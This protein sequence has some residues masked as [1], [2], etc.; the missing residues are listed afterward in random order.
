MPRVVMFVTND[1]RWDVRVQR[2]AATLAAAGYVVTV[3]GRPS[4]PFATIAE[5]ERW[6][7]VDIIRVPIPG[8]FRRRMLGAGGGRS[9]TG[10]AGPSSASGDGGGATGGSM[11]PARLLVR[12][13]RDAARLP[14]IGGLVRGLDLLARWRFG[15]VAWGSAAAAAA[16][17]ADVWHAHDLTGIPA[18][19]EAK[20]RH[21]GRLVY[22]SHEL[23]TEAGDTA[24]RPGWAR[25]V[26]R[27]YE[28]RAIR[29]ADAVVTVNDG[30]AAELRRIAPPRRLVV[31][32]NTPPAPLG[33]EREDR[34]R[35]PPGPPP[36]GAL[37]ACRARRS[38]S[39][40]EGSCRIEASRNSSRRWATTGPGA[41][42]PRAHGLRTDGLDDR[43]AARRRPGAGGGSTSCR[44]FRPTNSAPWV[45]SADVG[46]MPNQPRTANERISTP[47]KLYECL[48]A[49]TPVVSSDFPERR[50]IIA[51]DPGGPLGAL[52][53]P[54]DPASIGA[55]LRSIL[56]LDADAAAALR[57][58]CLDAARER[59]NW[60]S[61]AEGLLALYGQLAPD[62]RRAE[63]RRRASAPDDRTWPGGPG[64]APKV[65][66][67]RDVRP[68]VE[69]RLR[70][71][72][73]PDGAR[74]RRARARR[75]GDRASR[76]GPAGSRDPRARRRASPRRC[77]QRTTAGH[78][79]RPG[80]R[81]ALSPTSPGWRATARRT[82]SQARAAR[83]V[84]RPAAIYHAMGFL[85]LPVAIDLA[86][87]AERTVRLRRP[88]P[89]R[90]GQQHR[91]AA[92]AVARALRPSRAVVGAP[93]RGGP[94]GE[95]V[96]RG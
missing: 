13:V 54:T 19:R 67:A 57:A 73:P 12:I 50:R 72:D 53:D 45:A 64:A 38:S 65:P 43:R 69:R 42:P 55:A 23:F 85:A 92:A 81:R 15:T 47:N 35:R 75:A 89:L 88:R 68:A 63:P 74:P 86:R 37:P 3:I 32:R 71:P 58:R 90:G 95:R 16:P 2:E 4:D 25:A 93:G 36:P 78:R 70:C 10:A 6:H 76:G 34:A 82:R 1:V 46:A 44:R 83:L 56:D 49:G 41:C 31:V 14:I 61:Q 20:R 51:D 77:R 30:L 29:D 94:Y 5:R 96:A 84:D 8:Q 26:L 59:W 33:R 7:G 48:A 27:R 39:T 40:T 18:A 66:Q 11:S 21:G 22:D 60:E 17:R 62:R 80:D 9:R 52:C 79:R 91:P 28:A 24:T 87:N